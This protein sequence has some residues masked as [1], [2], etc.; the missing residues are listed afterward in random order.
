MGSSGFPGKVLELKISLL[1][2]SSHLYSRIEIEEMPASVI[3]VLAMAYGIVP[4]R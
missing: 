4:A 1:F 2:I 3:E